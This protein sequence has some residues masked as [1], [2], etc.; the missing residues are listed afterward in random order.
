MQL[1]GLLL[2]RAADGPNSFGFAADASGPP[3][4]SPI[5]YEGDA[6]TCVIAPT[7]SGKGRDFLIPNLLTYP[8]PIIAM[9][10]KGELSAVCGR[11]RRALGQTVHVLDP[12]GVTGRPGDRLNPFDQFTLPKTML[13]P[14]SEMLA[15]LLGDGHGSAKEPF[16]PDTASSLIAGL[17]AYIAACKTRKDQNIQTLRD[18]LFG[19]DTS[20]RLAQLLDDEG[21]QM[22]P[23]AYK[24]I[25]AFLEHPES[26]TRPSVLSTARTFLTAISS[27]QVA[28]CLA[29][30]TISLSDVM[31]G[32][33]QSIF[34]TV[35]PEKLTSHRCLLRLW[36]GVLLTTV[37][38]R[39]RVPKQRTLFVLDEAAQLGTFDPLLSA[40]TLLRGF[41]L[42]LVMVWQDLAQIKSRY[43]ADWATIV[44]NSAALLSFGFGHYHAAREYSEVLGL[45]PGQLASLKPE[46]AILA[47]RGDGT[48]KISRV[49]YLLEAEFKGM[50]DPNP[51]FAEEPETEVEP[52]SPGPPAPETWHEK[53]THTRTVLR[54]FLEEARKEGESKEEEQ[55]FGALMHLADA[56]EEIGRH[57]PPGIEKKRAVR[58][59]KAD[60]GV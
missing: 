12:F 55:I 24:A 43:P 57:L 10:P 46:E 28:H 50:F 31:R 35:P 23:F 25:G 42:Q 58:R 51:Y 2:G 37:M 11:A 13:E 17:V 1:K 5:C 30:S 33:P 34:I 20:Y 38:R 53:V 49:N 44:N 22:P 14:D 39:K 8:G 16:W 21:K 3:V 4:G 6:P 27:D 18:M 41:G 40:T 15:S 32:T 56:V 29:D 9:D 52:V 60:R 54:R 48:R 26:Q 59:K 47:M 36:V 7:G 19:D 45:D